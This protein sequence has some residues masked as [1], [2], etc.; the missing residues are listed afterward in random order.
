MPSKGS[1][2]TVGNR[3]NPLGKKL[4][5]QFI[6]ETFINIDYETF[7]NIIKTTNTIM[8]NSVIEEEAGIK[9]PENLGNVI[10]TKYKS[11][12]VPTDW[13]N[14]IKFQKKIPLLNL[15][16]FGF[17]HHI[18]WFRIG[19]ICANKHIYKFVPYRILKRGVAKSIKDG[20]KYFTWENT[21]LWSSTKM[22]RR[23]N[24]IYKKD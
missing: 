11:K 19:M 21:D 12:K 16:S 18:K 10:V 23:F 3:H 7:C 2:L 15:H 6:D 4:Y 8:R 20:K 22:E 13:I 17:V 1:K 24:K 14:S 9:L 5:K